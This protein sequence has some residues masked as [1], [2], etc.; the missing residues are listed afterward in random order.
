MKT[1]RTPPP[2]DP[3]EPS[4][5][6]EAI[7]SWGLDYVV[8]T[9]VDRDDLP[10][11]GSGHFAET[12]QKLKKLKP[13]MLIEALGRYHCFLTPCG[14]TDVI[15]YIQSQASPVAA[16]G[17]R[18]WFGLYPKCCLLGSTTNTAYYENMIG[19]CFSTSIVVP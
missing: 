3:N 16:A 14:L 19:I 9:S 6:A 4:N 18:N 7:A 5:V 1:S 11:Q 8:I 2:P 15:I 13:N 10:D 12:V 17:F